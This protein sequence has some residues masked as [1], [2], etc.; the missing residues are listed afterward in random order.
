MPKADDSIQK[1]PTKMDKKSRRNTLLALNKFVNK[2]AAE[3]KLNQKNETPEKKKTSVLNDSAREHLIVQE[4]E[5][6]ESVNH[7]HNSGYWDNLEK[8]HDSED[9]LNMT[10]AT[11][12]GG[13]H[14]RGDTIE[15]SNYDEKKNDQFRFEIE[16]ID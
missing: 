4:E 15:N 8:S 6:E 7:S 2:A 5:G 9:D 11:N 10:N 12:L 1:T 3:R 13:K 14:K 16:D